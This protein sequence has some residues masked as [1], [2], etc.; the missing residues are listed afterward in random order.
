MKK[1]VV[2][3]LAVALCAFGFAGCAKKENVKIIDIPLTDE[4]YAFGVDPNQPELKA[5]IDAI[6]E[7]IMGV[8]KRPEEVEEEIRNFRNAA[9][10]GKKD[11]AYLS[12]EK[13]KRLLSEDDPYWVTAEHLMAYLER[14]V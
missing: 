11:N 13:L 2:A 1:F 12:L 14:K 7:E 9:M 5:Q 3:V 10:H 8:S 6:L 4:E